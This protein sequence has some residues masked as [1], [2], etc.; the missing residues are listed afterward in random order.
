[1]RFAILASVA[2][3]IS[4]TWSPAFAVNVS[5]GDIMA[6]VDGYDGQQLRREGPSRTFARPFLDEA[7]PTTPSISWMGREASRSSRLGMPLVRRGVLRQLKGPSKRS[8]S[9]AAMSSTT[10]FRPLA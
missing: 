2:L 3:F 4:T 5:P 10:R 6:N 7:M 9:K 1:M 8:R